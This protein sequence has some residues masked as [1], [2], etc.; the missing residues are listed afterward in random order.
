MAT[1]L[2]LQYL[3]VEWRLERRGMEWRIGG[4]RDSD[5]NTEGCLCKVVPVCGDEEGASQTAGQTT[6]ER[7]RRGGGGKRTRLERRSR[8]REFGR[9]EEDSRRTSCDPER[10]FNP[11]VTRVVPLSSPRI[12]P[13]SFSLST[14][15]T[16]VGQAER[17]DR[18]GLN[19]CL[20]HYR[21]ATI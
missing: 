18:A 4:P 8:R 17:A 11:V 6:E 5:R 3:G 1:R 20:H 14:L 13:R 2:K 12:C 19:L 16:V 10:R 9:R 21:T 15:L 7:Q